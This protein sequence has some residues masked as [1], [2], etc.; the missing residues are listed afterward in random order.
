[1]KGVKNILAIILL[2]VV[3]GC[4]GGN[5]QATEIRSTDEFITVD[6]TKIYPQKNLIMQDFMDVEYIPLETKDEFLTQGRS[7]RSWKRRSRGN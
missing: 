5:R 2:I 6:V 3:T 4:G 1:M 7:S